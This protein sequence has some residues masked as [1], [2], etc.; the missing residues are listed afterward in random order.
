MGVLWREA[1]MNPSAIIEVNRP[2]EHENDG[3][4]LGGQARELRQDK[5][6]YVRR[7]YRV[8]SACLHIG[9]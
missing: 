9:F 1:S 5:A 6:N 8:L 3:L 7:T 4:R 2:E